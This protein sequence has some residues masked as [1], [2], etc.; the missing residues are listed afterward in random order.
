[1]KSVIKPDLDSVPSG[2]RVAWRVQHDTLPPAKT[3]K[4]MCADLETT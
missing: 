2:T 3:G 4:K 1:M